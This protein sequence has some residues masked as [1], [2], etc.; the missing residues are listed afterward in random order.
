MPWP[1]QCGW[2][3]IE[4]DAGIDWEI[5]RPRARSSKR[6]TRIVTCEGPSRL[7]RISPGPRHVTFVDRLEEEHSNLCQ[8]DDSDVDDARPD[9]IGIAQVR[10]IGGQG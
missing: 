10:S 1:E 5:I 6:C 8:E 3:S 4:S 7:S 2:T 9:A